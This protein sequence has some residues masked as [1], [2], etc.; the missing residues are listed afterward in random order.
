MASIVFY[1]PI[2][3]VIYSIDEPISSKSNVHQ[4]H[5]SIQDKRVNVD[6]PP[7]VF[8]HPYTNYEGGNGAKHNLIS[9]K[10]ATSYLTING[11]S[12]PKYISKWVHN[13]VHLIK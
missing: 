7:K 1:R 5:T 8:P 2:Y 13:G 11:K 12:F 6:A 4:P 9:P 10:D 3:A